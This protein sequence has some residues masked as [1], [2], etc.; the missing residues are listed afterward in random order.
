[1]S[2]QLSVILLLDEH[3]SI[4]P[5]MEGIG[6]QTL[7]PETFEIILVDGENQGKP[8]SLIVELLEVLHKKTKGRLK[9][10]LMNFDS[11]GRAGGRNRA[12]ASVQ[13]PVTLLW[14]DDFAPV[15][16]AFRLHLEFHREH[17]EFTSV[18][19]GPGLFPKDIAI[20]P[21]MEWLENSG[22]LFG[23][24]FLTGA[25]EVEKHQFFYGANA[26]LKTDFLRSAGPSDEQLPYH[27]FDDDELGRRLRAQKMRVHYLP[28][29]IG[30]HYHEVGLS[31]R[32]HAMRQLGQS[33]KIYDQQQKK[34]QPWH[35]KTSRL[36]QAH[37]FYAQC[38][39]FYWKISGKP[40]GLH[41]YYQHSMNAALVEGYRASV[42]HRYPAGRY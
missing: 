27:A 14:A 19:V 39:W 3:E 25:A 21:F 35:D 29:A 33:L 26:S 36:P 37:R 9:T 28:E 32:Q 2:L 23:I 18:A 6:C 10:R 30:H 15:P 17:P 31:E 16:D 8:H 1:V 22:S 40:S 4:A 42:E 5:V 41:H 11:I 34:R 13:T 7:A 24:P 20:T 38:S 12:L